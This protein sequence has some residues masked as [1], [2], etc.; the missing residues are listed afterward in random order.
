MH[1]TAICSP[2][3]LEAAIRGAKKERGFIPVS[4]SLRKALWKVMIFLHYPTDPSG[5]CFWN[6][7]KDFLCKTH[8]QKSRRPFW[9][10]Y[11]VFKIIC[12]TVSV[13]AQPRVASDDGRDDKQEIFVKNQICSGKFIFW[14]LFAQEDYRENFVSLQ[15]EFS[16]APDYVFSISITNI[17]VF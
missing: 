9:R 8:Y 11:V 7:Q 5:F 12:C 17:L 13:L 14:S 16:C 6:T 3:G 2:K 1:K 4:S 15:I 10:K